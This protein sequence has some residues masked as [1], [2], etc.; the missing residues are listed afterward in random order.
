MG[1]ILSGSPYSVHDENAPFIDFNS[2]DNIPLLGICY[3][4]QLIA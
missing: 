4:A 3:G 1:I 2:F